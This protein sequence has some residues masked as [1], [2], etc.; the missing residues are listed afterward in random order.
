MQNT[1]N[2]VLILIFN[3]YMMPWGFLIK[4]FRRTKI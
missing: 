4:L 1:I 3:K 2:D